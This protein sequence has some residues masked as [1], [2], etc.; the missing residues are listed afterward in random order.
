[1]K[2]SGVVGKIKDLIEPI[3]ED[4]G[5]S[6]FEIT[7]RGERTGRV[8]RVVIDREDRDISV[9]DCEMVSTAIDPVIDPVMQMIDGK[10]YFE[11]SSPGINRSLR[12]FQDFIRFSGRFTRI[13][14]HNA[15]NGVKT[16]RGYIV[17]CNPKDQT[18]ELEVRDEKEKHEK[19][20]LRYSDVSKAH[21]EID[22]KE[23]KKI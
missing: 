6:I 3:L 2:D 4:M 22:I 13:K 23:V 5:F 16:F 12:N 21:L 15:I 20:S 19:L 10:Y 14:L 18:F 11:V 8:L 9:K 7:F 1:M 17:N